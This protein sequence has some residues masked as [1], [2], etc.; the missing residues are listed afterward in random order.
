MNENRNTDRPNLDAAREFTRDVG[1]AAMVVGILVSIHGIILHLMNAPFA[2]A[3]IVPLGFLLFLF[4]VAAFARTE[5]LTAQL[6]R[7]AVV[8]CFAGGGGFALY[9][10]ATLLWGSRSASIEGDLSMMGLYLM[11]GPALLVPAGLAAFR[12]GWVPL[13]VLPAIVAMASAS[14]IGHGAL[15]I[16]SLDQSP[17]PDVMLMGGVVLSNVALFAYSAQRGITIARRQE[18][19]TRS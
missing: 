16:L 2:E 9:T 13:I 18:V 1:P 19:R 7:W 4:G 6:V 3:Y 11:A 15:C 12:A 17:L 5:T 10:W 14:I 8:A